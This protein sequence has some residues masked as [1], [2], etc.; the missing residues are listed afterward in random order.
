MSSAELA[1]LYGSSKHYFTSVKL[2]PAAWKV[3]RDLAI[4]EQ[5]GQLM[6]WGKPVTVDWDLPEGVWAET[7]GGHRV[8]VGPPESRRV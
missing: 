3:F 8:M 2:S 1:D 4:Y 6:L 7:S 5:D